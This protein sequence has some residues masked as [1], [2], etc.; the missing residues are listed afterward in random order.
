MTKTQK[1][2]YELM[3]VLEGYKYKAYLCTAGKVSVGVGFNMEQ[4]DAEILWKELGIEEDFEAV[5]QGVQA[6]S[7]ETCYK[8]FKHFWDNI[9]E[10]AVRTRCI[11]LN[12]NYD[13][14]PEYK[15][16]TLKDIVYNTGSI[17]NWYK[18]LVNI[19]PRKVMFEARR[20]PYELMDSRV[21]KIC[22]AYG[23]CK[24]LDDCIA[25]G[26]EYAKYLK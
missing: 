16:F 6:I 11:E 8:L 17:K 5:Y 26:L 21:A 7:D 22:Y 14:M 18:V 4:V 23:I 1:Q 3:K 13:A 19:D 15:K 24:D 20:R 25:M 12:L 9:C 2:E 10:I